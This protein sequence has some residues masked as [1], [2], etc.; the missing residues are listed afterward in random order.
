MLQLYSYIKHINVFALLLSLVVMHYCIG[1]IRVLP[2]EVLVGAYVLA[3]LLMII[4][5]IESIELKWMFF[6]FFLPFTILLGRPDPIFKPWSRLLFFS[7]LFLSCSPIIQSEY[8]RKFRKK[9]LLISI[10]ISIILTIGS[11]FA[12]FLGINFCTISREYVTDYIGVAGHFS[13]ITRQSMILG[14]LSGIS[15]IVFFIYI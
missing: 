15:S 6:L 3:F 1:A 7:V 10:I 8:A 13:G 5:P 2:N 4:K 14:P 11:F 12:Y 9:T